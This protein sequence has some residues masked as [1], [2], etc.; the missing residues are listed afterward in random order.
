MVKPF[1]ERTVPEVL[2]STPAAIFY[3]TFGE[4]LHR[5]AGSPGGWPALAAFAAVLLLRCSMALWVAADAHEGGKSAAYD[6]G[7]FVFL[8]PLVGL[9]Y[10]FVRHGWDG[11]E[12]LGWYIVL[13]L[14]GAFCAWLPTFV[15]FIITG[16][17]RT[18]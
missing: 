9:I 5:A 11:F 18:I 1:S 12:P 10:L 7:S 13:V 8:F 2:L 15:V 16:Q 4:E 3:C 17:F 14:G 6:L